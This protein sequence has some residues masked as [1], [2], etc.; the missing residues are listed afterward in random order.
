M[1][2]FTVGYGYWPPARRCEAMVQALHDAGVKLVVDTRHS[3]CASQP[4]GDGPYA[5]RDW[6]LQAADAGIVP[7]LQAAGIEYRWLVELGNPQKND[8]SMT[9]LRSHLA[10]GDL[11]WPVNRGM[12]LLR[13]LLTRGPTP[14]A[15]MC[16][17]ASPMQCHR[18]LLAEEAVRRF[19][20]LH[21]QIRHLPDRSISESGH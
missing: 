4:H 6:N 7:R 15:L 12:M 9:I 17:C 19:P 13:E 14:L 21:L 10:S 1:I 16:A 18:R 3:P 20:E 8:P 11:R 2:L 5:P